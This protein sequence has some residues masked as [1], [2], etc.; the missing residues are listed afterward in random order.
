MLRQAVLREVQNMPSKM[1]DTL[2]LLTHTHTH[3]PPPPPVQDLPSLTLYSLQSTVPTE[4]L[5]WSAPSEGQAQPAA[6]THSN[7]PTGNSTPLNHPGGAHGRAWASSLLPF[8]CQGLPLPGKG[9]IC[10]Y[11]HRGINNLISRASARQESQQPIQGGFPEAASVP[12][13]LSRHPP[14]SF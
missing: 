6:P 5:L 11:T 7:S 2:L 3:T 8:P 13:E 14:P 10:L 1:M 4:P 9:Q 12:L